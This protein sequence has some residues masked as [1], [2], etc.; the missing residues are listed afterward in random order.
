MSQRASSLINGKMS[1]WN[2]SSFAA[3]TA[4]FVFCYRPQVAVWDGAAERDQ[5]SEMSWVIVFPVLMHGQ[6]FYVSTNTLC[7]CSSPGRLGK[8]RHPRLMYIYVALLER[9][10]RGCVEDALTGRTRFPTRLRLHSSAGRFSSRLEECVYV[11]EKVRRWPKTLSNC[12]IRGPT[13]SKLWFIRCQN[14]C[15]WTRCAR[16]EDANGAC[17][18]LNDGF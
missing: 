10:G 14:Q 15:W 9:W 17:S 3:F 11:Y 1:L 8:D 18:N 4:V 16:W 6:F 12:F 7:E 13:A 5:R 2:A